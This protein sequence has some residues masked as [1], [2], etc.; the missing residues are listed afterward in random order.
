MDQPTIYIG[1]QSQRT[2]DAFTY[3]GSSITDDAGI[4]QEIQTCIGRDSSFF[5]SLYHHLW[6]TNDVSHKVKV[7]INKF[8][9]FISFF[10]GAE[11]WT[12]YW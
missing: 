1:G 4:D 5:G 3:L 2:V 9:L 8:E 10:Y 7:D 12:F 11:S 6:N